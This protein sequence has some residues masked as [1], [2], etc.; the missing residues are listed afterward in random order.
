MMRPLFLLLFSLLALSCFS[1]EKIFEWANDGTVEGRTKP[2]FVNII[3]DAESGETL[4]T[5]ASAHA[6]HRFYQ[7]NNQV[8][9]FVNQYGEEKSDGF[10]K[11]FP[12]DWH[13]LQLYKKY[14]FIGGR[15]DR[16]SITEIVRSKTN[17]DFLLIETD[18]SSGVTRI[19][20]TVKSKGSE[21][22][23]ACVTRN[24]TVYLLTWINATN[25]LNLYT[26]APGQQIKKTQLQI[27]LAGSE[28]DAHPASSGVRQFADIF[29]FRNA[30][31]F[32][33]RIRFPIAYACTK[34]KIYIQKNRIVFALS[35]ARFATQLVVVDLAKGEYRARSFAEEGDEGEVDA[36]ASFLVDSTLVTAQIKNKSLHLQFYHT[37]S[38]KKLH[39]L[40][41]NEETLKDITHSPVE[42]TGSFFSR[43]DLSNTSFQKFCSTAGN[44][45][46]ALSGYIDNGKL[47][48]SFGAPYTQF[49]NATTLSNILMTAGGTYLINS[50][51]DMRGYMIVN[52]SGVNTETLLTFQSAFQ[53]DHYNTTEDAA[54]F[55]VWDR[56]NAHSAIHAA[57]IEKMGFYYM[58]GYFYT[59]FYN[60]VKNSFA[61][62]RFDERG[63]E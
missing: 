18:L 51:G 62:Y 61:M 21:R 39:A 3:T 38:G 20:D 25:N 37:E 58:N 32:Q 23:I 17:F 29:S 24:N 42:K 8:V 35:A 45:M 41:I 47:F 56:I 48:L 14:I 31:V 9:P 19:S 12:A 33:N 55:S 27:D 43:S 60:V 4:S 53:L 13:L 15:F 50:S 7:K 49:M 16:Q 57:S 46:L 59:A 63:I 2:S 54:N 36:N 34:N 1:Q 11:T 26:K 5:L 28:K 40:T 44:N 30:A 10:F 52:N 6:L 22:V